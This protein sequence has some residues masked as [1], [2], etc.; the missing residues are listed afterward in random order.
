MVGRGSAFY[1]IL[2]KYGF[3]Q[4]QG[5]YLRQDFNPRYTYAKSLGFRSDRISSVIA[6]DGVNFFLAAKKG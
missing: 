5:P 2:T 4:R 3:G 6:N 1:I